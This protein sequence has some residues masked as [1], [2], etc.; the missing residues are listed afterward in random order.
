MSNREQIDILR[1][2]QQEA[3]KRQENEKIPEEFIREYMPVVESVAKTISTGGKLP[4]GVV[5]EDLVSWGVE[6]LIKAR[7]RFDAS[8]GA[9]F[10]TY[11]FYRIRGEIL[12]KIRREWTYRNPTDY[13]VHQEKV[14]QRIAEV[15]RATLEETK[16]QASD[17][18]RQQKV[19]DLIANS[20]IVYLLSI[21]DMENVAS[22]HM[23]DPTDQLL[24]KI[25]TDQDHMILLEEVKNLDEEERKI[26]E[27][28]YFREMKQKEI[29]DEL[30]LSRS[31]VCRLHTKILE[32]LRR[33]LE[34]RIQV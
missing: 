1:L 25:D 6:G 21:E 2:Q 29:A 16:D 7:K 12:D 20:G 30:N 10:R 11:A 9:Q 8:K 15:V 33:R 23:E 5:Y 34:R 18:E 19:N 26:I 4:L 3:F 14:Q 27:M 32:K 31:K 17:S 13:Q 22:S 28:F 24:N